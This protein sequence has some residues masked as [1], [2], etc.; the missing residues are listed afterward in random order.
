MGLFSGTKEYCYRLGIFNP[1]MSYTE[2]VETIRDFIKTEEFD[3][4]IK[5]NSFTVENVETVYTPCPDGEDPSDFPCAINLTLA[6][7]ATIEFETDMRGEKQGLDVVIFSL[8]IVVNANKTDKAWAI[9]FC[10][11]IHEHYEKAYAEFKQQK[12]PLFDFRA[13]G[14]PN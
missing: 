14:R 13:Y 10:K 3:G 2:F 11:A 4:L 12:A 6:P 1:P 5:K 7:S 9:D 8:V